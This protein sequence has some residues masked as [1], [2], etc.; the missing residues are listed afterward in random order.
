MRMLSHRLIGCASS[1]PGAAAVR[2]VVWG[3]CFAGG[4][5]AAGCEDASQVAP[6]GYAANKSKFWADNKLGE[7]QLVAFAGS[8]V[9]ASVP[10]TAAPGA[11]SIALGTISAGGGVKITLPKEFTYSN[12]VGGLRSY[13]MSGLDFQYQTGY[14]CGSAGQDSTHRMR[15]SCTNA[16]EA[17]VQ[18]IRLAALTSAGEAKAVT[19]VAA[20]S[21]S[22][23]FPYALV[24]VNRDTTINGCT[25]CFFINE[26]SGL[27]TDV[28]T[29]VCYESDVLPANTLLG[30]FR[31]NTHT[32]AADTLAIR[33]RPI[34]AA[35]LRYLSIE[36]SP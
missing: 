25:N 18:N 21:D 19:T 9:R 1:F 15:N 7:G 3:C 26:M 6:A 23:T 28:Y 4:I 14:A 12:A 22:T 36:G 10:H 34:Q 29:F 35:D 20:L 16:P 33:I 24:V 17:A 11:Q 31:A 30:V 2:L 5:A 13:C 27:I 32:A 8:N